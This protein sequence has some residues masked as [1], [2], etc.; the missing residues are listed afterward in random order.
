MDLHL[1]ECFLRVV[2]L[3]SINKA[4][5]HLHVSQPAL[6]RHIAAL[7]HEMGAP[8]FTRHRGGVQLTD[9]G[10]LL[11]Q[12]V[13]PLM[14][15]FHLLKEQVGE[16][17]AGQLALGTPPAWQHLF[18]SHL[19]QAMVERYPGI[20]LRVF[21]GVSNVLRDYMYSRLLDLAIVPYQPTPVAGYTQTP[22][23]REPLVLV[24]PAQ[25]G[26]QHGEAVP[27]SALDGLKLVLPGKP[28]VARAQ[29]EHALE[30]KGLHARVAVETDTLSLCLDLARRGVGHTVIPVSSLYGQQL[31]PSISW[32]P[33]KAQY[34]TWAL[35]ENTARA[36]SPAVREARKLVVS[37]VAD[38]LRLKTW[39]GAEAASGAAGHARA[40]PA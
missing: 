27:V 25:R 1:L 3:G 32:A 11:S 21:E 28:N 4:A 22:L 30:R 12:R 36:H 5:A 20:A 34:V 40:Q 17:A 10:E 14:R 24:G 31:D 37:T 6:S 2:E 16:K 9:A 8:L 26:P 18:T 23:V 33:V 29:I 13:R 7:E 15:Q 38:A 39:P 19:A 35:C